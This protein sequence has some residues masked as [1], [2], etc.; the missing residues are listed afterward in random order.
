[1]VIPGKL[2]TEMRVKFA[3]ILKRYMAGDKTLVK[4]IEANAKS[5]HPIAQMARESLADDK[6]GMSPKDKVLE[7]RK[8]KLEMDRLELEIQKDELQ[9]KK[10][11]LEAGRL[12]LQIQKDE[13][14]VKKE[15][16]E[17]ALVEKAMEDRQKMVES[18]KAAT[19]DR[20]LKTMIARF[21]SAKVNS[22]CVGKISAADLY[23]QY[24]VFHTKGNY[25][26][27]QTNTAFGRGI[28][29]IDGIEKK[30][31]SCGIFYEFDGETIKQHLI[32]SNEYD[33]KALM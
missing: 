6:N 14:Q 12:E 9:V 17:L 33:P 20:T 30:R 16:L 1:M 21:F 22:G 32:K 23:S 8:R 26:Y 11:K 4:E 5:S 13:I 27:I 10:E 15:K 24:S 7:M 2:A 19:I 3:N 29:S 31:M 28:A 25:K 18:N